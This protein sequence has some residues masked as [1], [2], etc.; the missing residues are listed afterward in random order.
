MSF[1]STSV[2]DF[3]CFLRFSTC[4]WSS[5]SSILFG[6]C[7]PTIDCILVLTQLSTFFDFS[8]FFFFSSFHCLSLFSASFCEASV[9]G[10]VPS[11]S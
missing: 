3:R 9:V 5:I 4:F 11:T 1:L 10:I 7:S 2:I 8:R 6:S